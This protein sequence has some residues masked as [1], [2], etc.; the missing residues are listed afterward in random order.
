MSRPVGAPKANTSKFFDA[1]GASP[2][3]STDYSEAARALP[4]NI[5]QRTK[6]EGDIKFDSSPGKNRYPL[7]QV[8]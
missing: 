5:M 1:G 7:G 2:A 3:D 8:P 6:L 4:G